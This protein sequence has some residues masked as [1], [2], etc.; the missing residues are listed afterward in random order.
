MGP[1]R[2]DRMVEAALR[3]VVR[4]A[5]GVVASV[6]LP[7]NHHFYIAFRTDLPGVEIPDYLRQ[8]FP[9][10]M[11]IVLQNRFSGLDVQEDRFAVTLYF[12]RM[13]E[14]L[15]VPFAA[16]T[17]FTDPSVSFVLQFRA[18]DQQAAGEIRPTAPAEPQAQAETKPPAEA[19]PVSLLRPTEAAPAPAS[20]PD[21][22]AEGEAASA[23]AAAARGQVISLDSFR[24]KQ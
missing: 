1:L 18:E 12:N 6:G 22:A 24:K 8:R 23:Q 17:S 10:D 16:V 20:S 15:V 19:R 7:G 9:R 14:R 13:P 5:L 2:Y 4:D 3:G 21:P 11:T